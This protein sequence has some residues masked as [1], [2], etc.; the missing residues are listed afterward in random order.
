MALAFTTRQM[1]HTFDAPLGFFLTDDVLSDAGHE[2][3]ELA[4]RRQGRRKVHDDNEKKCYHSKEHNST[5]LSKRQHDGAE[6][7]HLF[8]CLKRPVENDFF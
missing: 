3:H 2:D 8:T 6:P 4:C 5:Y 1:N 7:M